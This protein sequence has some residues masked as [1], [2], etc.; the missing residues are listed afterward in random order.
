MWN[1]PYDPDEND[2]DNGSERRWMAGIT[3]FAAFATIYFGGHLLSF[4]LSH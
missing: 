3:I 1:Y 4:I 2:W